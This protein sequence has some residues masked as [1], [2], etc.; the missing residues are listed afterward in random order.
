MY[1]KKMGAHLSIL[2]EPF[3]KCVAVVP[4]RWASFVY[5]GNWGEKQCQN[6]AF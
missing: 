2:F 6:L 5:Y 3:N 1:H 4:S